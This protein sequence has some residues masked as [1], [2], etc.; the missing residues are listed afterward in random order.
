MIA[1]ALA[2]AMAQADLESV[3]VTL[4]EWQKCT[5]RVADPLAINSIEAPETVAQAAITMCWRDEATVRASFAS[6]LQKEHDQKQILAMVEAA[7]GAWRA[8]L[9]ATIVQLRAQPSPT[10]KR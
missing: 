1:L 5:L 3:K 6:H 8:T 4:V 7:K 10:E 2:L 9:T